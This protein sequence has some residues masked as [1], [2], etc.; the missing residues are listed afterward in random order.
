MANLRRRTAGT[1]LSLDYL[2]TFS[3]VEDVET[4]NNHRTNGRLQR[5]AT[6][7]EAQFAHARL[8]RRRASR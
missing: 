3:R 4:A 8:A 7:A 6:N 5:K 1:R 2:G